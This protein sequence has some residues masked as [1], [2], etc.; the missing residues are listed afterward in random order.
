MQKKK[1]HKREGFSTV[2]KEK[3]REKLVEEIKEEVTPTKIRGRKR[4]LKDS[5]AISEDASFSRLKKKKKDSTLSDT[6]AV[7]DSTS[8]S[9]VKKKYILFIG[10]LSLYLISCTL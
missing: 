10:A 4:K 3:P 5:D 8:D 6:E 9:T 2:L 1:K 7:A